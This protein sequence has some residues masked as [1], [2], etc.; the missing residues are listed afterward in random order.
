[1]QYA[2]VPKQILKGDD[3]YEK[4][5]TCASALDLDLPLIVMKSQ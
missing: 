2:Q 3:P 4:H 1:M 5:H